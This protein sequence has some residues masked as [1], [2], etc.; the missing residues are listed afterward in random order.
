[1]RSALFHI[2]RFWGFPSLEGEFGAFLSQ[3][4]RVIDLFLY[5]LFLPRACSAPLFTPQL[6]PGGRNL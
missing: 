1:M 3:V 2:R 5:C 6:A 4:P